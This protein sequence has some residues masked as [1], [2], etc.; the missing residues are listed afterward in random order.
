MQNVLRLFLIAVVIAG[1]SKTSTSY[2]NNPN[3]PDY[4]HNRPVGASAK[5]LL[6][7]NPYTSLKIEIQYMPGFAP[8]PAALNHLQ[9]TLGTLL[10]KP[11]GITIVT[12]QVPASGNLTLTAD[13][14]LQIERNNR[15]SFTSG[16]QVSVYVLY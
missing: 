16:S 2:V 14:I 5:D 6:A 13:D 15:T 7:A 8:D 9:T 12:N 3:A 1:C 10:N 4:L 11:S